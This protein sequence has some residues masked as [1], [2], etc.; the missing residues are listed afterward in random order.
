[1][2]V[3]TS[4]RSARD[5]VAVPASQPATAPVADVPKAS[6]SPT[7][8]PMGFALHYDLDTQ[9]M[10]LEVREPATGYVIYQM[11]PKYVIKQ[12][13][14]SGSAVASPARGARVDSAV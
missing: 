1:M 13:S 11:P 5:A 14:T 3:P 4:G 6:A 7:P 9:R 2:P 8:S 12:F 10:I